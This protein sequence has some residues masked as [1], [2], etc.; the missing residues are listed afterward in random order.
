MRFK[1]RL[2]EK[3]LGTTYRPA[4]QM[5]ALQGK[6]GHDVQVLIF[7]Q[8]V[9]LLRGHGDEDA[10]ELTSASRDGSEKEV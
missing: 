1:P 4:E 8:K 2:K 9:N 3:D 7:G 5:Q 10:G 6:V